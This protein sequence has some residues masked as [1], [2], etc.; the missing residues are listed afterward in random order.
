MFRYLVTFLIST[1]ALFGLTKID[2]ISLNP[3]ENG[4][5]IVIHFNQNYLGNIA[6]KSGNSIQKIILNGAIAP[7]SLSKHIQNSSLISKID[8]FPF[9]DRT[10]IA[11]TLLKQADINYYYIDDRR[12]VVISITD[13]QANLE[14]ISPEG[15]SLF[16]SISWGYILTILFLSGGVLVLLKVRKSIYR[17]REFFAQNSQDLDW[18]LNRHNQQTPAKTPPRQPPSFDTIQPPKFEFRVIKSSKKKSKTQKPSFG[19]FLFSGNRNSTPEETNSTPPKQPSKVKTLFF[20]EIEMGDVSMIEIGKVRYILLKDRESGNIVLI[21]KIKPKK[22]KAKSTQKEKEIVK[23]DKELDVK[24]P[25]H[26]DEKKKKDE[27]DELKDLFKDA[28]KLDI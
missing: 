8:I 13:L 26:L 15:K 18:V 16:G 7:R 27:D 2:D 11:L 4:Y 6:K 20:E 28:E 17:G 3:K 23:I 10:D 14:P 1:L 22:Q 25:T 21:D 9:E 5:D 12:G 24:I 19:D